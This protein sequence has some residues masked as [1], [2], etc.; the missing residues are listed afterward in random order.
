M[1]TRNSPQEVDFKK[2]RS[3]LWI[4]EPTKPDRW[5]PAIQNYAEGIFL[6]F[7]KEIFEESDTLIDERLNILQKYKEQL[8]GGFLKET[9]LSKELLFI[10]TVSHMLIKNLSFDAGYSAAS[11]AER[12]YVD[13]EQ[14]MYG[15]LIYT[16]QGDS[17]STMG[18]LAS[19]ED[20]TDLI[21]YIQIL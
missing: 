20:L 12:L 8:R 17:E 6:E 5:L 2:A 14:D 16:A 18:G 3:L 13:P 21:I 9:H 19:P 7:N 11:I 1:F 15:V 4:N 10:H